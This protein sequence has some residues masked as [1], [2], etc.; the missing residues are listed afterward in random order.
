MKRDNTPWGAAPCADISWSEN[1]VPFSTQFDDFYYSSE[2]GIAESEH[3]FLQGNSLPER[4]TS[5]EDDTFCILETGFGTGL[6]FLLTWLAWQKQTNNR[7][8]LHFISLEKFP[9]ST[10]ELVRA[11]APWESL[12]SLANKL[13]DAWPGRL[14]GQ[15]RLELDQ[16]RVILDLWWDDSRLALADLATR[17]PAIDAWYLDG[18][19]PSRN[20][21]MWQPELYQA[22]AALSR[23]GATVSTFTAASHV[24]RGLEQAGF[25]ISKVPG[26]GQKRES[27]RGVATRAGPT[28]ATI[29]T[30][31]DMPSRPVTKPRQALIIGAGLAGCTLAAALAQRNISV[32][33]LDQGDLAGEASGNEQGVLYTRLSKRHSALTDFALQSFRFSANLYRNMFTSGALEPGLDGDLCGS[34]HQITDAQEVALIKNQLVGLNDLA[35]ALTA[36]EASHYLGE[37]PVEGGYW[38]PDSGWLRPPAVCSA[39]LESPLIKFQQNCGKVVLKPLEEQWQAIN[40]DNQALATADIAI[41]CS[42]ASSASFTETG[43][44][45]LQ[46]IRGQT[47]YLPASEATQSLKAAFCHRGYISPARESRHC[48]GASFKLRDNS[49]EVRPEE[50]R[51]NLE[52]LA[53]ALPQWSSELE[54]LDPEKMEGRVGFRCASPDYLP[55]AGPVPAREEFLQTYGAL[56]KNARQVIQQRGNYVPGLYIN[57]AHGSR[58][59]S[60]AP[61]CAQLLASLICNELPPLSRELVRALSPSRFLIRDLARGLI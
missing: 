53:A 10:P 32:T 35:E 14:P 55:I 57:T 37:T 17:G 50:H 11:L 51:E 58:G 42:G 44:L 2:A 31:W 23:P 56:R 5:F 16:G 49:M 60:S 7:P 36:Q 54:K 3:V 47:S 6:N 40:S 25:E 38:Y 29:D 9:L 46:S 39:M 30:P 19:T 13:I 26:F 59:L 12:S 8:R 27:L 45:P 15:H 20:D 22:M 52:K 24:R 1:G 21:A 28:L 34:F 61:L 41:I 33:V 18:F 43:W 48:I 4:W